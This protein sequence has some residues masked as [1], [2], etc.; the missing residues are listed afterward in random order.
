MIRCLSTFVLRL[1]LGIVGIFCAAG[2]VTES[3]SLAADRPLQKI[4]VAF[5]SISG[6]MAPLWVTYEKGFFRKHGLD[7]Q[8]ILIES[9]TTTAQALVAGDISFAQVA[10]PAVIQ[11]N[12]RGADTVMIA[13]VVNTLTFQLFTE[14]GITRP[15]QFKG[16]S[17]GVTRFGSATDFAMR[18]ALDKYG[19]D[20]NKDVTILQLGN[21]PALLAAME[22]AKIQGAMLSAPTSLRAKKMGFPMLADL[23]MLGLEYQHTSIATSRA[24]IKSKPELVRDFMRAYVEGIHY[25]KTHRK[26][27]LEVLTKYLRTDDQEVLD[28]MY[29]SILLTLVPEKPYPTQKGIQIILR[30]LGAKD[31]AAR[32]ARPEQFT[33]LSIVKE[34]DDSGFIDRLYKSPAVAKAA[35]KMEPSSAPAVAKASQAESVPPDVAKASVSASAEKI[36]PAAKSAVIVTAKATVPVKTEKAGSR[37]YVVKAGDTLSRLSQQ[38]YETPSKWGKIYEANRDHVKNPNYIFIGMKLIIPPDA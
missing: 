16:K 15:D 9:G 32:S 10:G 20:V 18:Y 6:N 38:F 30:E 17:V 28:D 34:L 33:D 22:A 2:I 3:A 1:A 12:L 11:S 25:A 31:P 5:S 35:P 14:K 26:E 8:V 24:L 37:E 19:L 13:G 4:N 23:Q 27:T 21:V 7:V 36:Q 29:E